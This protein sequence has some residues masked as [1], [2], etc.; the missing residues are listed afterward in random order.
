MRSSFQPILLLALLASPMA[1]SGCG[2]DSTLAPKAA[3]AA[4]LSAS[5]FIANNGQWE[6][7]PDYV[8]QFPGVDVALTGGAWELALH[9]VSHVAIDPAAA[10]DRRQQRSEACRLRFSFLAGAASTPRPGRP[11]PTRHHFVQG[12]DSSTWRMDVPGFGEVTYPDIHPGVDVRFRDGGGFL[13]YDVLVAEGAD[14]AR[15][16]VLVEGAESILVEGD[17]LL[18]TTSLGV[19]RQRTPT[20][21]AITD[22]GTQ[23][24]VPCRFELRRPGVFGFAVPERTDGEALLIDPGMIWSTYLGG[25]GYDAATTLAVDAAGNVTV[26]GIVTSPDFGWH[27][28]DRSRPPNPTRWNVF[29]AR[30]SADGS[31]LAW[32]TRLSGSLDDWVRHLRLATNGDVVITGR[33]TSPDFP[34]T[35]G[36]FSRTY[37][38]YEDVFVARLDGNGRLLWSTLLGGAGTDEAAGLCVAPSDAVTVVG[39][40]DSPTFPTTPGAFDR[41][42]A[43]NSDAFALCLAPDGSHLLWSTFLGGGM[44]DEAQT[45]ELTT[46]GDAIV[47]G[48][49]SSADFPTTPG[50]FDQTH[51]GGI[52]GYVLR[53]DATGSRLVWSTFLGGRLSESVAALRVGSSELVTCAGWAVSSDFPVTPGAWRTVGSGS[54]NDGFLARLAADGRSLV[55]STFFDR[56]VLALDVFPTGAVAIGGNDDVTTTPGAFDRLRRGGW[57]S[58]FD[59]RGRQLWWSSRLAGRSVADSVVAIRVTAPDQVTAGGRTESSD[60]PTTPGALDRTFPGGRKGFVT[61][62]RIAPLGTQRFGLPTSHCAGTPTI[63]ALDDAVA[64]TSS[65]GLA[66]SVAPRLTS[67]V[68]LLGTRGLLTPVTFLGVD[69]WIDPASLLVVLPTPMSSIGEITTALPLSGVQPGARLVAQYAFPA[70]GCTPAVF[71]AS[72]ALEVIVR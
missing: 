18:I 47:G 72:D 63:H 12:E 28:N 45:V 69:L 20:T 24:L 49:T 7:G 23:R 6:H 65:F 31:S 26:A 58:V 55:W 53:L 35:A 42:L 43:F 21:Y 64:G 46:S 52:D 25:V 38:G 34:T 27:D 54:G 39:T 66:C 56:A 62:L 40:T 61:R 50:A 8:A 68:V 71:T 36:A 3:V 57:V 59:P 16:E 14:L 60:F 48:R 15:A 37:Q 9:A 70:S 51:N 4:S 17:D 30:L 44:R 5:P 29:V 67:G 19:L 22:D 1:I 32:S 2:T 13:E 33:T 41:T 11:H 10:A